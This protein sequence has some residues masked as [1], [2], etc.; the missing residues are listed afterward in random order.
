MNG[1]VY[2]I[3]SANARTTKIAGAAKANW[4][5]AGTK[6]CWITVAGSGCV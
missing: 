2:T 5:F 4:N 3:D 6:T 1:F